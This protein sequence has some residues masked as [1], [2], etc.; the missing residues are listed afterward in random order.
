MLILEPNKRRVLEIILLG[1][2]IFLSL[3][4]ACRV[5]GPRIDSY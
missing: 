5:W 1:I 2:L 4:S 3:E